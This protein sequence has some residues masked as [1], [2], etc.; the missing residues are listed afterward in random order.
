MVKILSNQTE[1]KVGVESV[2]DL[3]H[4]MLTQG[5]RALTEIELVAL[6]LNRRENCKFSQE[7]VRKI[8]DLC[9]NQLHE[10]SN[11]SLEDFQA[12]DELDEES[13]VLLMAVWELSNR[14]WA[15]VDKFPTITRSRDAFNMFAPKLA[16]LTH[17]EFHVA[18]L[19]RA[20]KV[21][22][23][24]CI[25][26]G[27]VNATIVDLRM[28]FQKAILQ[29]ASALIAAHNHP[30]GLLNPSKEDLDLTK[31]LVEGSGFFDI[32]FLDHLILSG[33]N[34]YSFA[35]NDKI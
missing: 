33:D 6:V 16:Y 20:N 27:G 10:F 23:Q 1:R 18:F 19:N 13:C 30:S 5:K 11:W 22:S 3:H 26:T 17:E 32:Q 28:I 12:I 15:R 29:K 7:K 25:S 14:R 24:Q 9:E 8:F 4:K 21:I 31:K 34:Y 35:D 2:I